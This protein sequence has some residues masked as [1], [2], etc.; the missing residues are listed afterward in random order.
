MKPED[1][2]KTRQHFF[3]ERY[4]NTYS[5]KSNP[6]Y[7]NTVEKN[8]ENRKKT[9]TRSI[10]YACIVFRQTDIVGIFGSSTDPSGE[11]S[12]CLSEDLSHCRCLFDIQRRRFARE[13]GSVVNREGSCERIPSPFAFAARASLRTGR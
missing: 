5:E 4:E 12:Q 2:S 1:S 10:V 6:K 11:K 13:F 9:L 8:S 7:R 3:G